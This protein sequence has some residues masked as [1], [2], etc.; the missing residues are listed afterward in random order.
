MYDASAK[1][2]GPSL[3]DCLYIGPKFNQKIFEIL[4]R[5][6]LHQ[7]ALTADIER[8]FLMISVAEND[9]DVLRFLWLKD[10][11]HDP[12]DLQVYQFTRVVFGVASSPFL[13]NATL[14]HHL[15]KYQFNDSLLVQQL[16]RS[17]Y[18]DDVVC[19]AG[20]E[21]AT[22]Q[23]YL[24]SKQI[25][26]EGGFNLRK[27]ITNDPH[28]QRKI[29]REENTTHKGD[30]NTN[31]EDTYAKSTLGQSQVISTG[32][33]KVLGVRWNVAMDELIFDVSAVAKAADGLEPTKRNVVS[34]V[35]RFF[36]PLGFLSPIVI[37]FKIFFKELCLTNC[38][39]DWDQPLS[40]VAL[41]KWSGLIDD[42]RN[43][44]VIRIS[45][46]CLLHSVEVRSY[47]LAGFCDTSLKAYSAVAYIMIETDV[48]VYCKL[49]S[50]KTKVSPVQEHTIPRLELLGAVLL[51]RL[52][53]SI[54]KSLESEI[55]LQDPYCYTD[56]KVVFYWVC[57]LDKGWK[58]FIQNRVNE[59]RKLVP[60]IYWKHCPGS[61]NPADAPSRGMT[62]LELSNDK[63]WFNGPEW[64]SYGLEGDTQL[65]NQM[66][67]ECEAELTTKARQSATHSLLNKEEGSISNLLNA[68]DYSDVRRLFRVTAHVIKFIDS[69]KRP[70]IPMDRHQATAQ[71]EALWIREVQLSL[72]ADPNFETWKKQLGLFI[73]QNG[74]WRCR[75]RLQNAEI[76]YPTRHPI[77][78]PKNHAFTKL[79]VKQA[80]E[81]VFHNG[82][83]E[84]LAELRTSYWVIQARALVKQ[85][86][87]HCYICRRFEA[88]PYRAPPPPPLPPFRV[89]EAPPFSCVGIDFAGP[90]Y[91]KECSQTPGNKV[92]VVLYT[93]CI[94]RAIHLDLVMDLS[95]QT[96]IRCF[97][98]FVARRSLP[99]LIVSDNGK[100]FKAA[101]KIIRQIMEHRDVTQHFEGLRIQWTFNIERAPWWGGIFERLI[102]STKRC[103]RKMIG[104]SRLSYDE[105]ATILIEIEMIIN[106][107]PITYVSSSDLEEPLTPSHLLT[108][109]RLL[110]LPDNLCYNQEEDYEPNTNPEILTRRMRFLNTTLKQFW[111]RWRREYLL[112]LRNSHRTTKRTTGSK[113]I[114]VG[115]MVVIHSDQEKRGF[116]NLG[117]IQEVIPG[118][119]GEIR[120]AVVRV[121]GGKKHHK[122]LRRPVQLLYPLEVNYLNDDTDSRND[123]PELGTHDSEMPTP[124]D[125]AP[126]D[127]MPNESQSDLETCLD[128]S[129]ST[130]LD[131]TTAHVRTSKES[132]TRSRLVPRRA[133]AAEARD[134][135]VAQT[136]T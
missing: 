72:L 50:S 42:L 76:P 23:I 112:E 131:M 90:L 115:D 26:S 103:L 136:L 124:E 45:R 44:P 128:P 47:R 130:D 106:S 22:Y 127:S 126:I 129:T 96:F 54:T 33:R 46:Y 113:T 117:L 52:V 83:N 92:W 25:L 20:Q 116:W 40:G 73:D 9:R 61:S 31:E 78:L 104:R 35:G 56:S 107:R 118:R 111:R 89:R 120:G 55:D 1:A 57:G 119:D 63:L 36:D 21:E 29:D 24:R 34:V 102:K 133:A 32:E 41:A 100:T 10:I 121:S 82:L 77:L 7:L 49:I 37:K 86:I 122:L 109:H 12:P 88:R 60:A 6:R 51:A 11:R 85:F 59:I 108:G 99:R 134:K 13:L 95:T 2:Q 123:V 67:T 97:K 14:R 5:F 30:Q 91:I 19:G 74:I 70:Q 69:L 18:V 101:T 110:N 27:F 38:K 4:L 68:K 87:G 114:S 94:T 28:L 16:S 98:R 43:G 93:C 62:P 81:R 66:P 75:G 84:T 15:E 65:T 64:L 17:I 71:A 80:H 135:I 8:A 125:L 105:L 39:L 3:N 79:V 53:N 58:P 132:P 48:S